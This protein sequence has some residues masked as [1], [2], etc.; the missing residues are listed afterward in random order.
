[1]E[2]VDSKVEGKKVKRRNWECGREEQSCGKKREEG[3]RLD[4]GEGNEKRVP[5]GGEDG[6][7]GSRME[8]GQP[9]Q[10]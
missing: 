7:G 1:L 4:L 3:R 10:R 8:G 2:G 9:G 6:S 5:L